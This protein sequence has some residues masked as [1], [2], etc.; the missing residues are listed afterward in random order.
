MTKVKE[1]RICEA[2][3]ALG[4]WTTALFTMAQLEAVAK[5]SGTDVIDVMYVCRKT[6]RK[7]LA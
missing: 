5:A 6:S 1:N 7:R 4:L 2:L 3:K